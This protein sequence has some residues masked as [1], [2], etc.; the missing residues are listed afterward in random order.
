MLVVFSII[1]VLLH[2]L[3][4]IFTKF[5]QLQIE[6]V[7]F[8]VLTLFNLCT[9]VSLQIGHIN[10][11]VLCCVLVSWEFLAVCAIEVVDLFPW[12][13]QLPVRV[14]A[15]KFC[16]IFSDIGK[17]VDLMVLTRHHWII[18]ASVDLNFERGLLSGHVGV[19]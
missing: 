11:D 9:A 6:T 4:H 15:I 12:R 8:P 7:S 1:R 18:F 13:F 17:I 14:V 5:G 10:G 3:V 16:G 19:A 2:R